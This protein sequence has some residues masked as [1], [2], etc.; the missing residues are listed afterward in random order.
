[1]NDILIYD[2]EA[3]S[4]NPK[5]ANLKWFG[6]YSF[7]NDKYFLLP[8]TK[9][10]EI[11]NL[12]KKHKILIGFNNKHYDNSVIEKFFQD[13]LDLFEYK[14]IVDLYEISAPKGFGSF[15]KYNKNRLPQMGY[16]LKSYSLDNISKSLGL[17]DSNKGEIDYSIFQKKEWTEKEIEQ[18]KE[19]LKQDIVLT[20]KLYEWYEEKF[21]PLK[22][23]LPEDK[24]RK[25]KHINSSL[26]SLSYQTICHK[27]G[28]SV[29]W[30]DKKPKNHKS[31][32]GGH[33]LENR[34][35]LVKGNI[36]EIDFTSAYPHAFLMGNLYYP[37]ERGEGWNGGDYFNLNGVYNDTKMS[38][39]GKALRDILRERLKAKKNDEKAKNLSYKIV[40]NSA[41]GLT[42][43]YKFKTLY[44]LT[45]AS[46]CTK[47]VRTW[48]RKIAKTLEE[49]GFFCIYGFTDSIFVKIPPESNKEELMFLVNKCIED[50]K[51]NMPFPQ[52]TFGMDIDEEIKLI[53][54]VAKNV[55][56]YVTK[57]N[58][59]KYKNTLFN[60][61][62]PK[63]VMQVFNKYMSKKIINDLDVN[64]TQAELETALKQI[65][66]DNPEYSAEEYK[67]GSP[68][69]YNVTSSLYYQIAKKY[70]AGRHFLIPN[71][72]G[73]GVGKAKNY[74][75][76]EEF[77]QNN[78][79][80]EDINIKQLMQHLNPFI[81]NKQKQTK[82]K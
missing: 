1:M 57:D 43:N 65:L 28:L 32:E 63:A 70:G 75:T 34:E 60:K 37:V 48:L 52:D 45:T 9:N 39:I 49:N 17:D 67:V 29:E 81:R 16:D 5:E 3:D 6:A 40:I 23:F 19:Y 15:G 4:K 30:N 50:I 44:N 69:N 24:Q 13:K 12:I 14:I 68:G 33:H 56:L 62:T 64:F 18:I 61:N 36:V 55:Y 82:L 72:K 80:H 41:Y 11:E 77:K 25:I 66:K 21:E 54:F 8:Y 26:S 22:K 7:K 59:I 38:V 51:Q 74:C 58:Q 42:G 73:I 10:L 20:K 27:A 35:N 71:T 47:I 78:L 46:D 53:W 79:T 2:I 31:Y 76:L